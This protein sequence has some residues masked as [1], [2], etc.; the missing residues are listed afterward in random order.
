VFGS[1]RDRVVLELKPFLRTNSVH[2]LRDYA[3]ADAGIVCIP[4]LV[5]A[6]DLLAGRLRVVLP[7]HRLSSFWLSAV[8]PATHRGTLKLRLFLDSVASSFSGGP[9][10]D[11]A[12]V[13][14]GLIPADLDD[15]TDDR[16]GEAGIR[17]GSW[18]PRLG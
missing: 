1:G 7:E 4:T 9:R 15:G 3:L 17:L 13:H 8:Y 11:Q 6:E 2:L 10:W 14:R 5:A 16:P 18:Q 12:L